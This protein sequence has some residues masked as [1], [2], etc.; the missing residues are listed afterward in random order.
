LPIDVDERLIARIVR[1][2]EFSGLAVDFPENCQLAHREYRRAA[3]DIHQHALEHLIHVVGFA[4]NMLEV[5][6]HLASL[7]IQRQRAVRVKRVTGGA[8]LKLRPRLGLR[9]APVH[10]VGGRIVTARD[11]SVAAR[12]EHQRLVVPGLTA[13]LARPRDCRCAPQFLAGLCVVPEDVTD[14]LFEHLAAS[15]RR[16]NH[17]FH[18]EGACGVGVAELRVHRLGVPCDLACPSVQ[19]D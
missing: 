6:R 17:A 5:P 10:E 7:R 8:A 12:A 9:R 19:R 18:G 11:P 15:Q 14:I 2:N 16:D 1:G 13:W 3:I 4:G